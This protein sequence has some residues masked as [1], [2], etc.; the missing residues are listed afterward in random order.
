MSEKSAITS[1]AP[2]PD[3]KT[4]YPHAKL[5]WEDIA[6]MVQMSDHR[7]QAELATI[8]HVSEALVQQMLGKFADARPAARK[9]LHGA[10]RQFAEDVIHASAVAAKRGDATPALEVLDRIDALPKRAS[11]PHDGA[12]VV[13]IVGGG[14]HPASLVP[15]LP[16][17]DVSE[18]PHA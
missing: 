1:A 10:A 13:V 7:T 18:V 3:R 14:T 6:L 15:T 9:R 8:F 11:G 4:L 17:I 5:S 12:K 16:T 2:L